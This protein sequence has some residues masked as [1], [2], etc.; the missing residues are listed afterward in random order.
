MPATDQ[1]IHIHLV[2][3]ASGEMI[4]MLARN[5]CALFDGVKANRTLW[6]YTRSLAQM[7]QILASIAETGGFV[8]HSIAATDLRAAL[9]QG[10]EHLRV[11]C[12]FAL[13]PIV[14]QMSTHFDLPVTHR[15]SVRDVIDEDYYRRVEAMKFTLAHDDGQAADDLRGADVVLVGVSRAT[16]TPTCMFLASQGIKAANVP[17]VPGIPLPADLRRNKEALVVGLTID[18]ARLASVR[19]ARL[20]ALRQDDGLP[21]AEEASLRREVREAKMLCRRHGW[22]VID[23]TNRSI[24]QTAAMIIELLRQHRDELSVE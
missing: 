6:K 14:R 3:H 5:A 15:T 11:P 1:E 22:D 2:S 23:V 21:Y 13:D 4:E 18:P 9:E 8:L 16:K 17:L 24:E 10:C 7:P 19:A 20:R 12:V